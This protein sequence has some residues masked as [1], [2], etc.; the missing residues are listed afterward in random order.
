MNSLPPFKKFDSGKVAPPSPYAGVVPGKQNKKVEGWL[1]KE[2]S[3]MTKR[4][5]RS[6]S[7][8]SE[9]GV[10]A[11]LEVKDEVKNEVKVEDK[12]I[13]ATAADGA[14][15]KNEAKLKTGTNSA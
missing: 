4:I 15:V 2:K 9:Y 1:S 10:E 13:I 3:P 7:E 6:V 5:A 14:E 11:E 8:D 12:T